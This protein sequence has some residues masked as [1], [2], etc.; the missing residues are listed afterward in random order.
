[1]KYLREVTPYFRKTS[2]SVLSDVG[3]TDDGK[4][5]SSSSASERTIPLRLCYVCRSVADT[6]S[7]GQSVTLELQSPNRRSSCLLRCADEDTATQWLTAI[8]NVITSL[9][10][11]AVADV[12]VKLSATSNGTDSP[13]NNSAPVSLNS[14]VKHL[15]W[16]SEQVTKY[17]GVLQTVFVTYHTHTYTSGLCPGLSG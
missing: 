15:G 11:R 8:C 4:P 10:T 17:C 16:L 7:N 1:M 9:T 3:W 12:N 5:S 2:S 14:D 6:G 13:N